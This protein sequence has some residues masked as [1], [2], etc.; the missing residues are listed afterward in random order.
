MQAIFCPKGLQIRYTVAIVMA[1]ICVSIV[2][3][4]TANEVWSR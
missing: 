3:H 2:T 4:S 1:I